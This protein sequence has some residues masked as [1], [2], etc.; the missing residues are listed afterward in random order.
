MVP[1]KNSSQCQKRWYLTQDLK[2]NK[3][4]W[5][6]QE[7]QILCRLVNVHGTERWAKLARLLNEEMDSGSN[8]ISTEQGMVIERNGKQCRERWL[9]AL[10]P[11]INKGHWSISNDIEFLKKWLKI[12]NKWKEIADK[13]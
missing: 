3:A 11:E 9:N 13:I 6:G 2:C 12:G 10:D 4:M 1:F 8:K 7:D 5:T